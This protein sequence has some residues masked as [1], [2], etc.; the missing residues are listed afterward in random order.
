MAGLRAAILADGPVAYWPADEGTGGPGAAAGT[1]ELVLGDGANVWQTTRAFLHA[2]DGTAGRWTA[3][4]FLFDG[5][6]TGYATLEIWVYLTSVPPGPQPPAVIEAQ[7]AEPN[8]VTYRAEIEPAT[9]R[10]ALVAEDNR[11]VQYIPPFPALNEWHQVVITIQGGFADFYID[12]DLE[13][14]IPSTGALAGFG[15]DLGNI[16]ISN[17]YLPDPIKRIP[18][19]WAHAA[20]W[21]H[22][23][24]AD[25]VAAHWVAGSTLP[26]GVV[27]SATDVTTIV[28]A[29][30]IP[31]AA[32]LDPSGAPILDPDGAFVLAPSPTKMTSSVDVTTVV[33][34]RLISFTS[35]L[36]VVQVSTVVAAIAVDA[37][38]VGLTG[39]VGHYPIGGHPS[40]VEVLSLTTEDGDD[41]TDETDNILLWE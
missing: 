20:V 24:T 28:N 22:L 31:R 36:S 17:G 34:A 18:G 38:M 15:P 27:A 11:I 14:G 26:D 21:D 8:T 23:L 33:A 3:P 30:P 19:Y 25:Q 41:L 7:G 6:G 37:P 2:L 10:V 16:Q 9:T 1:T 40:L 4:G 12:G 29:V 5:T 13:T 32:I 35:V 39:T